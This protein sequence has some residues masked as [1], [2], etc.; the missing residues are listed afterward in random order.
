MDIK[1]L[2]NKLYNMSCDLDLNDYQEESEQEI[3]SLEKALSLIYTES[4]QNFNYHHTNYKIL[5]SC[6]ERI[7]STN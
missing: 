5:L 4:Q 2:A 3:K 7:T 1:D 6:L